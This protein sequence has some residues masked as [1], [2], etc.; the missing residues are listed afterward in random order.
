MISGHLVPVFHGRVEINKMASMAA[1]LR[2]FRQKFPGFTDILV[3]VLVGAGITK[4]YYETTGTAGEDHTSK[5][6]KEIKKIVENNV[7]LKYGQHLRTIDVSRDGDDSV[8]GKVGFAGGLGPLRYLKYKNHWV[9]YD[10]A[11]KIPL[12]VAEH[13]TRDK[14]QGEAKRELSAFTSDH[15]IPVEFQA[16]NEDFWGSGWSR[17]HMAP[18]G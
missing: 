2:S 17:G 4:V 14:V 10:Q 12:W 16:C 5:T 9:C 3:G 11:K 8:D 6:Q 7:N 1:A 13:L 18:A 15:N